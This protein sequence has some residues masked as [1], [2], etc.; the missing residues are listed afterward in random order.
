[1]SIDITLGLGFLQLNLDALYCVSMI[2]STYMVD[3]FQI[4]FEPLH[5]RSPYY[6]L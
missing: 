4:S 3:T 6:T 2:W 5:V 1:M